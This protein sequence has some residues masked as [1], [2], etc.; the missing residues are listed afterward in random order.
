[1]LYPVIHT[2]SKFDHTALCCILKHKDIFVSQLFSCQL[3]LGCSP[4]SKIYT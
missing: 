1:M 2:P 3:N 4:I